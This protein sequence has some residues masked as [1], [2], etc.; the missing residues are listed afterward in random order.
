MILAI[1][2]EKH[3]DDFI[4]FNEFLAQVAL[5]KLK[6]LFD[7][8]L[9]SEKQFIDTLQRRYAKLVQAIDA[10]SDLPTKVELQK[11][12]KRKLLELLSNAQLFVKQS[13]GS[14]V[15]Q[16]NE[17]V[18]N[19]TAEIPHTLKIKQEA[20][21]YDLSFKENPI[22]LLRKIGSNT[23][24]F[25]RQK[26][27]A[28][29]NWFQRVFFK[30]KAERKVYSSRRVPFRNMFRYYLN[31]FLVEQ[32]LPILNSTYKG[33]SKT[34]L[35]LWEGDNNLDEQFQDLLYRIDSDSSS[36]DSGEPA[37]FF[38]ETIKGFKLAKQT[39]ESEFKLLAE[40]ANSEFQDAFTHVDT[41]NLPRKFFSHVVVEKSAKNAQSN[42]LASIANWQ[43]THQT[44]LDDWLLDVEVTLLYYSVYD[45]FNLLSD[46]IQKFSSKDLKKLFSQ[47]KGILSK[48]SK[49][50]SV[51][52]VAKSKM[53]EI[54]QTAH[55]R[56]SA[57]LN[58][59][60]IANGIEM[61]THCFT[62]D[63][64]KL[65][66]GINE[67]VAQISDERSF[68][69]HKDYEKP[70]N[71][72]EIKT[73]SP[74]ELLEFEALPKFTQRLKEIR[75]AVDKLLENARL[76]LVALGTVSDFSVESA[77]LLLK[78]KQGT[79]SKAKNTVNDGFDRAL[80]YLHK[81]E[82]AINA[83]QQLLAE[84][85]SDAI[86]SFNDDILKL[87]NTDNIV[88]L[89]LR[90]AKIQ[91]I[92]RTKQFRKELIGIAKRGI[93]NIKYYYKKVFLFGARSR[94]RLKLRL[95][96]ADSIPKVSFELSEFISNTQQS[97]KDLP[98]VYQ[99]LFRL[100]PTNEERF[101]ANR[102]KELAQLK[103]AFKDWKKDRFIT[104]S[105]IGEKGSGIT[106]LLNM[107]LTQI[108]HDD[109][110]LVTTQ[111]NEK[112]Y[113]S[114]DYYN[115]FSELFG[116]EKF[117][118][119]EE[120][121][122]YLNTSSSSRIVVIENLQHMFIKQV[123]GF[124]CMN[125]FFDLMANTMKKVLWVGVYTNHSWRYL[126][127][128]I[129]IS[130][131]FTTELFVEPLSEET[132]QEIIF[133]RNALSGFRIVFL[134]DVE[135]KHSKLYKRMELTERQTFLQKRFF[136]VLAKLSNGNISLAMLY[137]LR[138]IERVNDETIEIR[139]I[140]EVDFSFI[141]SLSADE[142]FALQ[143]LILHDGLNLNNF[144]SVISKPE[145]VCRNLLNPML[146]KGYLIKP[147]HKYN[148]NPLIFK[149]VADYLASRNFV[150]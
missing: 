73:I 142:L 62:D 108:E 103:Q 107:F 47:I 146:E 63:F 141:K 51:Q 33:Y 134:P 46:Q 72:G 111:L 148:I 42:T 106:S 99:R 132:I 97:L 94:K 126:D 145:S 118:S 135:A 49:E 105:V 18:K 58:D 76:N 36:D 26:T 98:Y 91:A 96:L 19:E 85:F 15:L 53:L 75:L 68:L 9:K 81:V 28:F 84:D 143:A 86:N 60:V 39:L 14:L 74:S 50:L 69:K 104:V 137:W 124:D 70:T 144:S 6:L 102:E 80:G 11:E 150:N 24:L 52:K 37:V 109:E 31:V 2:M 83:I 114:N 110:L 100:S 13:N 121:I 133:K 138:S 64:D 7:E 1:D 43:N 117:Q 82:D 29:A 23:L 95:G 128:T 77:M 65:S 40:K 115:L 122:R 55:E 136:K 147:K 48:I 22:K 71:I 88:E 25:F 27:A 5:P 139:P 89:N 61:L 3:S 116:E 130:S 16:L 140:S 129:H 120:I 44:L 12:Y 10:A 90:I 35:T 92:N 45:E 21:P 17:L 34:L 93:A 59:K 113:A 67:L 32:S 79:V 56:I 30:T 66:K 149:P 125:L 41:L 4:K 101:F 87:K 57:D 78:G 54:V 123:H 38:S 131:Y 20:L 112:L 127:K 119:N 8:R